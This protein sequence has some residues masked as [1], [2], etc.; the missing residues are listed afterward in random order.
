MTFSE[1]LKTQPVGTLKKLERSTGLGYTTLLEAR[2]GRP[3]RG[4]S[5][6]KLSAAIR[7]LDGDVSIAELV[8]PPHAP[9]ADSDPNSELG[10]P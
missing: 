1:W 8:C 10:A 9:D 4:A 5:A 2:N 6:E 3:M 7:E